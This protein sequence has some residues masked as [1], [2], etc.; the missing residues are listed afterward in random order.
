M[1]HESILSLLLALSAA[2]LL[3]MLVMIVRSSLCPKAREKRIRWLWLFSG[4]VFVAMWLL[5]S[6]NACYDALTASAQWYEVGLEGLFQTVDAFCV[7]AN[8]ITY[9]Q[10]TR[11]MMAA[12]TQNT[13]WITAASIYASVL[14]VLA[15][16]AGGAVVLDVLMSIFPRLCLWFLRMLVL[17]PKYYFSQLNPES[18]ALAKSLLA[19]PHKLLRRPVIVFAGVAKDDPLVQE[20]TAPGMLCI[21]KALNDISLNCHGV[22]E[23]FLSA[24]NENENIQ[25]LLALSADSHA[26]YLCDAHVVL[27][28]QTDAYVQ[29]ERSVRQ[30]LLDGGMTEDHLPV[31]NPVRSYRNLIV[32]MLKAVPLYEPLMDKKPEADGS[33][34]LTVTILGGGAIGMEMLLNT[35]W[36]GQLPDCKLTVN[37]VSRESEQSFWGRLDRINPELRHTMTPGHKLLRIWPE[38]ESA[39]AAPYCTVNYMCCDVTSCAFTGLLQ[40]DAPDDRLLKTDYFLVTLGDDRENI[41]M[42]EQLCRHIGQYHLTQPEMLRTVISYVVYDP[43]MTALLNRQKTCCSYG[44]KADIYLQAV[45]ALD[46]VYSAQNILMADEEP[47]VRQMHATY[48]ARDTRKQVHAQRIKDDYKYWGNRARVAHRKYKL[49]AMG[50]RHLSVFDAKEEDYLESVYQADQTGRERVQRNAPE[51]KVLFDR[52]AWLEHRRWNAFTRV[53][54]FRHSDQY[55]RYGDP[56]KDRDSYKHM[57]LM[58]HPCLVEC[59]ASGLHLYRDADGKLCCREDARPDRLDA[60]CLALDALHYEKGDMKGYDYPQYD[61]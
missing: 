26:Q 50:I 3:P 27:F 19:L 56:E 61:F 51:D 17:R 11:C 28:V 44:K 18:L 12:V 37:V 25:M 42:A 29:V 59:D 34:T 57:Q 1:E 53:Y 52:L 30:K 46:D 40:A 14:D 4:S 32:N 49:Y 54:G 35:Y 10:K 60:L 38:E 43:Q 33:K 31:I 16:V 39:T 47:L 22:R 5:R 23:F 48:L 58:L 2:S 13:G 45:G 7:D 36:M 6:A 15:P 41:A 21:R 55:T 8:Y 24:Q 20:A 9:V